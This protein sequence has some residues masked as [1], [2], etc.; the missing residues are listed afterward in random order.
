MT[1]DKGRP[2][3]ARIDLAALDHNLRQVRRLTGGLRTLA[4]VKADAYGHGAVEVARRLEKCAADMLGV[5]L[6]E[7]G[8]LLR[9]AGIRLPILL[10]GG[11][12]D[13]QV[14]D[15]LDLH[16]TPV[17]YSARQVGRFAK[18]ALARGVVMP[19]HVKVD[20]GMGRVGTLPDEAVGLVTKVARTRGLKLEG[21]MTH[22]S[23]AD[24][25]DSSFTDWQVK[26]FAA[27]SKELG[28]MG[29]NP[30]LVH[31]AASA[32]IIGHAGSHFNMVRPGIMLYGCYPSEPMRQKVRLK[33]VMSLVTRVMALKS[34]PK[35]SPVSYGR[36]YYTWRDSIVALLPIGYADGLDRGL[37]NRGRALV[38][39]KSC[40]IIGRVC[41]DLTMV[42][43]TDAP[44]VKVGDEA[45]LIGAQRGLAIT[46]EELA[47]TLG[48]ISYE[49]LC[50][51]SARVPRVYR[52]V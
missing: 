33:P 36:S 4:V 9:D 26:S 17:I 11:V 12:F 7:E 49:V 16:L 38:K 43:V 19:V 39:G 50:G 34:L 41:M 1:L 44:G 23:E 40:P 32:G 8:A 37:S 2:T 20:T 6:V 45:A 22:L 28:D 48:S 5:A 30:G 18:A 10:L 3:C 35:G 27:I 13:H 29:I 14:E 25:P 46:A 52:G 24:G 47:T 21:L 42:D 31:A 15:T 51:I